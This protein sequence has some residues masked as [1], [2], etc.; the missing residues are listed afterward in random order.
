M[1]FSKAYLGR[2]VEIMWRDPI[3]VQRAPADK[4]P[5]G[6]AGLATWAEGGVLD[7]I[8]DGVGRIIHSAGCE[9]GST[10]ADEISY[11]LVPEV[12]VAQIRVF[13]EVTDLI[14][15]EEKWLPAPNVPVSSLPS[16][17]NTNSSADGSMRKTRWWGNGFSGLRMGKFLSGF[18]PLKRRS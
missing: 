17:M 13:E 11:T 1:K 5:R 16:I 15:K 12:L 6:I 14:Q 9:P 2:H 3:G 18:A 10:S 7:D 4:A 8:T